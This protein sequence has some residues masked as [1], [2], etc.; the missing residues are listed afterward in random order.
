MRNSTEESDGRA[1]PMRKRHEEI[2]EHIEWLVLSDRIG[3][4]NQLPSERRLMERFGVGR[5][6]VREALFKLSRMR[7][8]SA[9]RRR[10]LPGLR[11]RLRN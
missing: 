10:A 2:V 3:S 5:S 8:R 9:H 7:S 1:A 6:T 4:G 11:G